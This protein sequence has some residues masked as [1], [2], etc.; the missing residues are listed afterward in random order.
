M[1]LTV[2]EAISPI[3]PTVILLGSIRKID[4]LTNL[5]VYMKLG[6]DNI[7]H[8]VLEHICGNDK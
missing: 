2:A 5:M 6:Q 1:T 4:N 7:G 8:T 3:K